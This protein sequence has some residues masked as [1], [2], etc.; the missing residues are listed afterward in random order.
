MINGFGLFIY[1]IE[2]GWSDIGIEKFIQYIFKKFIV[3]FL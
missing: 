1:C 3:I 2:F